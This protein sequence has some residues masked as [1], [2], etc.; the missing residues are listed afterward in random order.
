MAQ[1]IAQVLAALASSDKCAIVSFRSPKQ[2]FDE[3][4]NDFASG[5][6]NRFAQLQGPSND[7]ALRLV[8]VIDRQATDVGSGAAKVERRI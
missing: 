2:N 8:I 1:T 5:T 3:I 6:E 7:G 4:F